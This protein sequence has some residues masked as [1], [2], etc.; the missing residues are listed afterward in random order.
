MT[1]YKIAGWLFVA[2]CVVAAFTP[3]PY[4][5][6]ALA[7]LGALVAC[8]VAADHFVRVIVSAI[9][10]HMISNTFDAIPMAGP[11]ITSILTNLGTVLAGAAV[12]V[13]L[14]KTYA[15]VMN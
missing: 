8:N 14:K 1:I 10:L 9:A 5:A 11:Y 7:L 6:L 15:R 12:L 2:L 4:A 13:I 3:I